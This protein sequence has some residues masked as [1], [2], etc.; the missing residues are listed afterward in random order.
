MSHEINQVGCKIYFDFMK[1]IFDGDKLEDIYNDIWNKDC[2]KYYS[3][4]SV[5]CYKRILNNDIK[6]LNINDIKS[7]G[8]VVSTLEACYMV[9]IKFNRLSKR[10]IKSC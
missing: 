10:R 8:F 5:D 7:N 2:T 1:R 6:N 3:K 4:E 9:F